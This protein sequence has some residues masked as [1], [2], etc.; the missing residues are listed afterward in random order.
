MNITEQQALEKIEHLI[1]EYE[2]DMQFLHNRDLQSF[3]ILEIPKIMQ[4]MIRLVTTQSPEFSNVSALAVANFVLGHM[5]GQLRPTIND[6]SYSADPITPNIYSIIIAKSGNGKDVSHKALTKAAQKAMDYVKSIRDQELK[7]KERTKYIRSMKK[8]NPTFD[9]TLVKESDY[10]SNFNKTK[11]TLVSNFESSRGGITRDL[12][13]LAKE[14]YGIQSIFESELGMVVQSNPKAIEVITLLATMYDMGNYTPPSFKT[15]ESRE[16]AI[17]SMFP[18]FLG[19]SSPALFYVDGPVRKTLVPALKTALA[20]RTTIIFSNAREEFE[21]MYIATS[22]RE[23]RAIAAESKA[24]IKSLTETLEKQFLETMEY[25]HSDS[26]VMFDEDAALL[27]SDYKG[28]TKKLS[29]RMLLK[30]GDSVEGLELSGR[31]WKMGRIAALWTMAQKS[32]IINVSTLRSAI[33]F[34]DY[35]AQHLVEFAKTLELKDYELFINDWKQGFFDNTLPLDK[36]ITKGYINVKNITQQALTNFLKPVNS[37]LQGVATVSYNETTNAFVFVPVVK[38]TE[39][40]YT[41]R[42]NPGHID[43][44]L[45]NNIATDKLIDSLGQLLSVNSSFNPFATDTTKFIVIQAVDSFLS[46]NMINKYLSTV[47]HFIAPTEHDHTFTI[48]IPANMVISRSEYKYVAM[49]IANQLMLKLPPQLCE[50][51]TIYNGFAG[52]TVLQADVNATLYDISGIL[53]SH[54]SGIAVPLLSAKPDIKPTSAVIAKY[55]QS[56]ILDNHPII[57]DMLNASS[58][59]LLLFANLVHDMMIH[60]VDQQKAITTVD[61]IN[62]SLDTSFAESVITE[63]L[64]E[65]FYGL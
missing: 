1:K 9:E 47:H 64:I 44:S 38:N 43:K 19:I 6:L 45:V 54:A 55:L 25:M 11:E 37:K 32:R 5:Y 41:Y 42:A 20:R 26:S 59:P 2:E 60:G 29:Q 39:N 65:P 22:L 58:N 7:E 33:Y 61:S 13:S 3:T 14:T 16:V 53:G 28:Y 31:A 62:A 30:D 18:N 40:T 10:W 17:E 35:T 63:Y 12:A 8:D 21:N 23:E 24:V 50:S 4:D 27:Y 15:D 57:V 46:A 49:T 52:T 36:A 56:E 34:C 48:L 51:D